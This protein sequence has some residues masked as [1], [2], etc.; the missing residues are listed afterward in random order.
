MGTLFFSNDYVDELD[1]FLLNKLGYDKL[2][3]L[4]AGLFLSPYSVTS[5]REYFAN[6]F[7]EFTNGDRKYLKQISP[8][9][10]EKIEELF[11]EN[12]DG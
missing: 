6:V 9:A 11:R 8:A 1:N 3:V 5:I 10:Y 7:E 12:Q 4:T 2:S